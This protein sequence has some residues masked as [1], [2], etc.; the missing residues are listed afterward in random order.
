MSRAAFINGEKSLP[1]DDYA[2]LTANGIHVET[3]PGAGHSMS[4]E[5]PEG[6][7]WAIERC[8]RHLKS[9]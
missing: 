5:N 4:V 8:V 1:D 7:A 6:L 3:V 9:T 2:G